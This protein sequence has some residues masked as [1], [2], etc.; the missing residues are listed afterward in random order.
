MKH[1]PPPTGTPIAGPAVTLD[2]VSPG[3]ATHRREREEALLRLRS[4]RKEAA[5]EIDRLLG[6]LDAS[7]PYVTTE[8]EEAVDDVARDDNELE[9]SLGTFD[10]MMDQTKAGVKLQGEFGA[11]EDAELDHCDDEPSLGTVEAKLYA[12]DG[13]VST[14]FFDQSKKHGNRDDCEGDE[15]DGGEPDVD[16]EWSLCGIHADSGASDKDDEPSLGSFDCMMDQ[17]NA[18]LTRIRRDSWELT[19]GEVD[20]SI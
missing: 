3:L 15:H 4:L 7:D 18:N 5:D 1:V 19:D 16:D 9:P 2:S 11:E 12:G 6:F 8:L 17:T 10:L 13:Y 20:P 14:Q